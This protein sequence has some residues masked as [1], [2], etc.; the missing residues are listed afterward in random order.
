MTLGLQQVDWTRRRL[1]SPVSS[2]QHVDTNA[3]MRA[4]K[5]NPV[6][7]GLGDPQTFFRSG[8]H[9]K[10][11]LQQS[12]A[13]ISQLICMTLDP[14]TARLWP[15][16]PRLASHLCHGAVCVQDARKPWLQLQSPRPSQRRSDRKLTYRCGKMIRSLTHC[17]HKG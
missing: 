1:G 8:L 6:F 9:V 5:S 3:Q 11:R 15:Q 4:H 2:A 10:S 17:P 13:G 16:G 12:H 14:S 7:L